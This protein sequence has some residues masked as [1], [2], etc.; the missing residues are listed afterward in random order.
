MKQIKN[1]IIL[2][3]QWDSKKH[4]KFSFKSIFEFFR[5]SVWLFQLWNT[6]HHR[7]IIELS[8][9]IF[10]LL[11]DNGKTFTVQYCKES[12][13]LMSKTLGG[14]VAL[15]SNEPRVATRRGLPLIIPGALRLL[16][17]AGDPVIIRVVF[18]VLS[19]YRVIPAYPKL[20]LG[21]ITSPFSGVYKDLP[22]LNLV[23]PLLETNSFFN[24][25]IKEKYFKVATGPFTVGRSLRLLTSAGPNSGTQLF[26][27]AIDAFAWR[28]N[29]SLLKTFESFALLTNNKNVYQKL[30]DDIKFINSKNLTLEQCKGTKEIGDNWRSSSDSLKLGKLCLKQEAAGKVRVFA[31]VDSWT[32]T[33]LGTLHDG[34]LKILSSIPQDGTYDQHKPVKVLIGKGITTFYSFDLSA[35]TDRLPI[36][37]QV[38]IISWLFNNQEVGPLWKDLLIDRDYNL[39]SNDPLFKESNGNYRYSVGQPMG[40]LSSWPM[41]ALSHHLIVQVAARRSGIL[42]WFE[43]YAVLG[44]DIVIGNEAVANCYLILM[45]DLGVSINLSKSLVS[46]SGSCEFAKRFY[47]QGKDVSPLGPKS[48]LEMIKSPRSFKDIVLNN[49]LIEVEDL[50][51]L[52]G[53]LKDLFNKDKVIN[54]KWINKIKSNYWDLVSCFGLDLGLDLSP[55][56]TAMAVD[57]LD[58]KRASD[59]Q[60]LI[61]DIVDQR[62]TQGWFLGLE[63]TVNTYNRYR[64][65]YSFS[66]ISEFPSTD[67][68]LNSMSEILTECTYKLDTKLD[69]NEALKLSFQSL[70]RLTWVLDKKKQTNSRSIK[71]LRLSKQIF[72]RLFAV[73][74][75]LALFLIKESQADPRFVK[76]EG[77]NW[78]LS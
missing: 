59:L 64:R 26:G 23:L 67:C 63:E 47:F 72:D 20:D 42:K 9:R 78:E 21:T 38:R 61:K 60:D 74:P 33:L 43:D 37:L 11:K 50:A 52:R 16:I 73:S 28:N 29:L 71:S 44:D 8:K 18:T 4:T 2:I 68:I 31:M 30:N 39:E 32:Q 36:D 54:S 25:F 76:R 14:E 58:P 15:S 1:N 27:Y 12:F 48:L 35:A 6:K 34:L 7:H 53:Q 65:F 22:E 41:L 13:R 77:I 17:E 19:V 55:N 66:S 51:I 10:R 56:L 24:K 3:N 49:S 70:S 40:C 62:L 46:A 5:V 69:E 57:S 75:S 45:S